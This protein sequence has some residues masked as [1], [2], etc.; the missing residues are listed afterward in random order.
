MSS[1]SEIKRSSLRRSIKLNKKMV[2]KQLLTMILKTSALIIQE[3]KILKIK[4]IWVIPPSLLPSLVKTLRKL[5]QMIS[6]QKTLS[7]AF[8]TICEAQF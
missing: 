6:V 3:A 7:K 1:D 4:I 2:G 5:F 8:L